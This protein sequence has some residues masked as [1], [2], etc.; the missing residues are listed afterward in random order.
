MV[1]FDQAVLHEFAISIYDQNEC[2]DD[3]YRVDRMV[4][5]GTLLEHQGVVTRDSLV[6]Q[7]RK[8]L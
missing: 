2:F 6:L 3:T 4:A 5:E 1:A 7:R 8:N